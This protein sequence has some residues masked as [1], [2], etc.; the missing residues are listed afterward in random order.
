MVF[1]EKPFSEPTQPVVLV[2]AAESL[3]SESLVAAYLFKVAERESR[4]QVSSQ[5]SQ[6]LWRGKTSAKLLVSSQEVLYAMFLTRF[7]N[8]LFG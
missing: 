8:M 6:T 4:K 1:V 3:R 2:V 5:H 7:R